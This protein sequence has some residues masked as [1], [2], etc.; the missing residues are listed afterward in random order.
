VAGILFFVGLGARPCAP[1][2]YGGG[3]FTWRVTAVHA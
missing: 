3:D 1:E 2:K